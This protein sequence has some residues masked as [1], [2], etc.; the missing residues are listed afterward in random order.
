MNLGGKSKTNI[1]PVV[2]GMLFAFLH[3]VGLQE[4]DNMSISVKHYIL[5]P[6]FD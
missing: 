3:H 5:Y 1:H 6:E 2:P 4:W